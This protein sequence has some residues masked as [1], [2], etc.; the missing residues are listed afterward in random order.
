M[1]KNLNE[2]GKIKTYGFRLLT[3]SKITPANCY[4]KDCINKLFPINDTNIDYK[5]EK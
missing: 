2:V 1:K 3:K 5:A 4:N